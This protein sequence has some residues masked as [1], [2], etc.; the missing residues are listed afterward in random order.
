MT[1]EQIVGL[2]PLPYWINN[3]KHIIR[4]ELVE[5][6]SIVFKT[7]IKDIKGFACTADVLYEGTSWFEDKT[8]HVM[9]SLAVLINSKLLQLAENVLVIVEKVNLILSHITNKDYPYVIFTL[10]PTMAR[11]LIEFKVDDNDLTMWLTW[12]KTCVQYCHIN[13]N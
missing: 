10:V 5:G 8:P 12:L 7:T 9:N 4:I 13:L 2:C 6:R 11:I 1:L 3:H